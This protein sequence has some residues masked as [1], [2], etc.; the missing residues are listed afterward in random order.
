MHYLF[1][2]ERYVLRPDETTILMAAWAVEQDSLNRHVDRLPELY[3]PPILKAIN[4]MFDSLDAHAVLATATLDTALYRSGETDGTDDIPSMAR[5]DN[6]WSHCSVFLVATL[7]KDLL[8][9]G[10]EVGTVDIYFDPKSLKSD[11]AEALKGTFRQL[12]T[13]EAKRY[14]SQRGSKLLKKLSIRR[15]EPVKKPG[16]AQTADRFQ[17]GVWVAD[18][19]CSNAEEIG[20]ISGGSRIKTYDMSDVVR[21]TLQQFDGKS[22]H[23]D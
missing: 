17:M 13:S 5:T 14:A 10:H 15:I 16:V 23:E 6:A 2:D 19:L 3:R 12:V 4:S 9:S 11:H 21:K 1:F 7:I 8:E 20:R 18:K 22:F